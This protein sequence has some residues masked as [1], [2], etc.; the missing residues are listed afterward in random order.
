MNNILTNYKEIKKLFYTVINQI[1]SLHNKIT[2]IPL[3][4]MEY[5]KCRFKHYTN[6]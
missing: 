2:L 6:K 3:K 4:C 5:D 1:F